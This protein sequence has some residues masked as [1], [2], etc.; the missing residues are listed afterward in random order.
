VIGFKVGTLFSGGLLVYLMDYLSISLAFFILSCIYMASLLLLNFSLYNSEN[1]NDEINDN[2]KGVINTRQKIL[3]L[4]KSPN[5]YW[6]CLFVLIY[7]LG[8]F[9][10]KF[11]LKFV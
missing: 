6:I 1:I 10:K 3:M 9:Q 2:G 8:I 11:L 5:T 7:K 4:H